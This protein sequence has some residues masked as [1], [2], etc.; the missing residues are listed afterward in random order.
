[1]LLIAAGFGAPARAAD[2]VRVQAS[3]SKETVTLA[4][5]VQGKIKVFGLSKPERVVVDVPILPANASPRLPQDYSGVVLKKIRSG[6]FDKFT[7]RIVVEVTDRF[8]GYTST[9][10]AEGGTMVVKL[11]FTIG[12]ESATA[13]KL[14][15]KP[16]EK[17]M[18]VIDAG[19]GGQDPGTTGPGGSQEKD[20]VLHYAK[21]LEKSLL[22][23]GKYRVFMT[24]ED[25]RFILLR[26]RVE[27]ARRAGGD[28]FISLHADSAPERNVRG[29]S[30][31]TLSE[32]ASDKEAEALAARENRADV[33]SGMDLSSQS[34]DVADI[35]ISLAQRDTMNKSAVVAMK[36]VA[37]M[38]GTKVRLLDNSHR[39]A[40]FAVLKAPDIPSVL[41]EIGFL[42]NDA[43]EKLLKSKSYRDKVIKGITRGVDAYFSARRKSEDKS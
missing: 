31:Y 38:N 12:K 2:L 1:M 27:L 14:Q 8:A 15:E 24:R 35:L 20:V 9:V 30:I 42:S 7:T 22:A 17:P 32:K 39:F 28:L 19:H 37:G 4:L 26:E 29:L 11:D 34:K 41:I 6:T 25:D 5:P 13:E 10:Q 18:V 23:T 3:E 36:L 16:P 33:V 40:G 21:A 43:E